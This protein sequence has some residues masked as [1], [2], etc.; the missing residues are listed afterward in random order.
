MLSAGSSRGYA[1]LSNITAITKSVE[2]YEADP[3]PGVV[4][5]AHTPLAVVNKLAT[6]IKFIVAMPDVHERFYSQGIVPA[7]ATPA[8]FAGV[9]KANVEKFSRIIKQLGLWQD[10]L[11]QR[12]N[13]SGFHQYVLLAL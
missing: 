5:P 7:N 6:E 12:R 4:A 13:R 1:R 9:I 2:G 10:G 11:P 3:W 8:E